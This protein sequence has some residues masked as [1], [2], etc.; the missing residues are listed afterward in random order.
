MSYICQV[1]IVAFI[2]LLV[3]LQLLYKETT[4]QKKLKAWADFSTLV[5]PLN[6]LVRNVFRL[7]QQNLIDFAP[8]REDIK[9]VE[10]LT[11]EQL[12]IAKRKA[13]SENFALDEF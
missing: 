1:E 11:E 10:R 5:Y 9:A 13:R 2:I 3:A 8:M 4:V 7:E 6:S 12:A